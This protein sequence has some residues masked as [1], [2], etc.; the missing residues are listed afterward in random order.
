[1]FDMKEWCSDLPYFACSETFWVAA[2][3]I[4][5]FLVVWFTW[6]SLKQYERR[7]NDIKRREIIEKIIKPLVIGSDE[8]E[9]DV[10]YRT[11][12]DICENIRKVEEGTSTYGLNFVWPS[13]RKREF[14][15]SRSLPIAIEK[16]IEEFYQILRGWKK[17]IKTS[18]PIYRELFQKIVATELNETKSST[19]IF[20]FSLNPSEAKDISFTALLLDG[21]SLQDLCKDNGIKWQDSITVQWNACKEPIQASTIERILI[22]LREEINKDLELK[23]FF[24]LGSRTLLSGRRLV[25]VLKDYHYQKDRN[26]QNRHLWGGFCV[27]KTGF[28]LPLE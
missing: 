21:K 28:Q 9:E 17:G 27:C 8:Y 2:S 13:I 6:K 4:G 25:A 18:F 14:Y 12:A 26:T 7:E 5:S 15:L 19:D 24:D 20:Y 10:N 3:A 1:M 23:A 22:R 11:I 16:A